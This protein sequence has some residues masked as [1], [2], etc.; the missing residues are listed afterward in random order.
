MSAF[1]GVVT[2]QV[3]EELLVDLGEWS[4]PVSV[5]VEKRPDGAHELTARTIDPPADLTTRQLLEELLIRCEQMPSNW[6][7]VAWHMH[8]S[9]RS[10]LYEAKGS[11]LLD[12]RR[13]H[14]PAMPRPVVPPA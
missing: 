9:I 7:R 1:D 5:R 3:A 6:H 8:G 11:S 12:G 14:P 2:I 4:P 10:M 13:L